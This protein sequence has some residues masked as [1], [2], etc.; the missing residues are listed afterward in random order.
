MDTLPHIKLLGINYT[1][2]GLYLYVRKKM[3]SNFQES[4]RGYIFSWR[5]SEKN[6][7]QTWLLKDS[8][9]MGSVTVTTTA[10]RHMY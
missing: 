7:F 9:E 5:R 4:W 6:M 3:W 1:T 2:M 8:S 10:R